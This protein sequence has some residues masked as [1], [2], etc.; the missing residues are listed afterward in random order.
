[1]QPPAQSRAQAAPPAA[2]PPRPSSRRHV[3]GRRLQKENIPDRLTPSSRCRYGMAGGSSSSISP[4]QQAVDRVTER[5]VSFS[6]LCDQ[7]CARGDCL[8]I[9]A[10]PMQ[11]CL[12]QLLPLCC[13]ASRRRVAAEPGDNPL[14]VSRR[15]SPGRIWRVRAVLPVAETRKPNIGPATPAGKV[16]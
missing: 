9:A 4:V 16:T 10:K 12:R 8:G 6:Q 3:T 1:L 14:T 7:S 15:A 13:V 5:R 11:H 2:M